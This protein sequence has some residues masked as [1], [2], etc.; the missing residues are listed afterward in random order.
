[1]LEKWQLFIAHINF[2]ET[3]TPEEITDDAKDKKDIPYLITQE[4]LSIPIISEPPNSIEKLSEVQSC[5]L[6]TLP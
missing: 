1:M 4:M 6:T 3:R 5:S 2:I